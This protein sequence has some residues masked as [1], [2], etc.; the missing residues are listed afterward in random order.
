QHYRPIRCAACRAVRSIAGWRTLLPAAVLLTGGV[1]YGVVV[2]VSFLRFTTTPLLLGVIVVTAGLAG[3]RRRVVGTGLVLVGWG[4]AVVLVD[5]G[6]VAGD[7]TTAAYML[8]IGT[9]L[10]VAIALAPR[11]EREKWLI[12]ASITAFTAP[13]SLYM[14]GDVGSLGRWTIWSAVLVGWAA[15]E[16]F[17][18]W[19]DGQPS[20]RPEP[21]SA[22]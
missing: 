18:G 12:S 4:T 14:A 13:L 11:S 3:T 7:R 1:V 8:G 21:V 5:H 17:W 22:Q 6:V 10:L 15:W 9:G 2:G 16:T 19:R 20:T